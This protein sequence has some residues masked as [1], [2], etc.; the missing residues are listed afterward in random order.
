M[1]AVSSLTEKA[2]YVNLPNIKLISIITAKQ[3]LAVSVS[4]S[5]C[6]H[7]KGLRALFSKVNSLWNCPAL[8][9]RSR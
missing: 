4:L 6:P 3:R 2:F 9:N 1:F 5:S 7:A 8:P